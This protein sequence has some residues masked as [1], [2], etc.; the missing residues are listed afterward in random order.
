MFKAFLLV[1]LIFNFPE[2]T[3]YVNDFSNLL[4]TEEKIIL[5]NRIKELE[6]KTPAEYVVVTIESLYGKTVK[7]FTT[8]LANNWNVGHFNDLGVVIL[9]AKLEQEIFIATTDGVDHKISSDQIKAIVDQY[10]LDEMEQGNYLGGCLNALDKIYPNLVRQEN[11]SNK[12]ELHPV[13]TSVIIGI[14][15]LFIFLIYWMKKRAN[16]LNLSRRSW[17]NYGGD[18]SSSDDGGFGGTGGG[19]SFGGGDGG[20]DGGD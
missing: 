6:R 2:Q 1:T 15:A 17:R 18:G 16:E 8:E 14:V 13:P 3:G 11:T 7:N 12:D 10:V 19:G 4:T 9:I 5:E 20:G